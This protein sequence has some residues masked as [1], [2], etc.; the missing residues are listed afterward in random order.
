SNLYNSQISKVSQLIEQDKWNEELLNNTFDVNTRNLILSI[1]IAGNNEDR[2]RWSL[3][4]SGNF[5]V[6]SMYQNLCISMNSPLPL[7]PNWNF[8]WSI[9]VIPRIKMFTWK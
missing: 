9:P 8:I 4:K 3:T 5:S 7:S 2:R 6:K 1:P